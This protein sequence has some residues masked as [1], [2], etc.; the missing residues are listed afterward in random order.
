MK[1]L[2]CVIFLSLLMVGCGKKHRHT[3]EEKVVEVP[4]DKVVEVP[5]VQDFEGAWYLPNGGFIELVA[6]IDGQVT[7]LRE[8]YQIVT[9]NPKNGT[10]ANHPIVTAENLE[11]NGDSLIISRDVNY[12]TSSQ[13]DIEEDVNGSNVTGVRKTVYTFQVLEDGRL[14]LNIKIFDG[15]TNN[16]INDIVVNRT[17]KAD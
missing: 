13:Y 3:Y 8:N 15:K 12:G 5:V 4:V 16:N 17:I 11:I 6:S 10:F 2:S 14:K 1:K 7:I 9:K